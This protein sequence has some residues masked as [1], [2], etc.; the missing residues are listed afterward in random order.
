MVTAPYTVPPTPPG[1]TASEEADFHKG[2]M[3]DMLPTHVLDT[4]DEEA[5]GPSVW[6]YPLPDTHPKR[7]EQWTDEAWRMRVVF[8]DEE[9]HMF[10]TIAGEGG[11]L[12]PESEHGEK[13]SPAFYLKVADTVDDNGRWFYEDF[14]SDPNHELLGEQLKRFRE[15]YSDLRTVIFFA[16]LVRTCEALHDD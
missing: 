15:R 14:D 11:V 6:P 3:L 10:D 16:Q 13:S 1:L 5:S 9:F 2:K 8:G 4:E 7:P 12:S